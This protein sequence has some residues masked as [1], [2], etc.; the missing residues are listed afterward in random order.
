MSMNMRAW[1]QPLNGLE[2]ASDP[3]YMVVRQLADYGD[4]RRVE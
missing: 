4:K 2:T 1:A 3:A